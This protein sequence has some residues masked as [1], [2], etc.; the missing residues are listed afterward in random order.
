MGPFSEYGPFSGLRIGVLLAKVGQ[1]FPDASRLH[2]LAQFG[3]VNVRYGE[4]YELVM[5]WT[6]R[7]L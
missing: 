7:L 2:A 6:Q 3:E 4:E 1:Q 5:R